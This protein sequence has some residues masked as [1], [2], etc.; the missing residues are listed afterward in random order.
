MEENKNLNQEQ[1]SGMDKERESA[2]EE[3]KR[4]KVLSPGRMVLQRF[5][6]NKLAII[7]LVILVIMFV[8]SFLGM[9]F[10]RYEVAQVFKGQRNIKKDYATAVY[11]QE[12]R[13]T[14]AEGEEFPTSARTQLMLAIHTPGDKTTFE[15]DGIGY[16][17]DKLGKDLYRIIEL[18]KK[19]SVAIKG[20]SDVVLVDQNFK[21]TDTAKAGF[22]AAKT[23]GQTKF[24]ADGK[25]YFIT[26]DAKSFY[27]C[28]ADGIALASKEICDFIDTSYTDLAK[29]YEFREVCDAAVIAESKSFQYDGKEYALDVKTKKD[30]SGNVLTR[31][32][33]I[34]LDGKDILSISRILISATA[35]DI[36]LSPVFKADA[37]TAI[38]SGDDSFN[39]KSVNE[40]GKKAEFFAETTNANIYIKTLKSSELILT[41]EAPSSKHLLGTDANGMDLLTR[42]MFGG[43]ISLAVG[44][45]V[46]G[47]ELIIGIIFGGISGYFGGW[48]DMVCMRFV[49]LFNSIPYWPMLVIAGAVM[50][51]M[52]L[53]SIIRIF[54]LMFILGFLSWP[55]IA[56]IVR[57]QI[58]T[59]REQEFM[60][61]CE[62]NGIRTSRRIFKHLVPNVM[63]ILIVQ[64]TMGLGGII[65]TEATLSFLGLG[66][67]YPMASWGSIIQG[68]TDMFVMTNY[69]WIWLPAGFCILITVLGFNFVGD[70]LRDA[71]DPKMKR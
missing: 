9:M 17:F 29:K 25:T 43:R 65:I 12:F 38:A 70:G 27:L 10:S 47:I 2:V 67:K 24:D 62:A 54:A 33:V 42:L 53:D 61:A 8:F 69:W 58:L 11:N 49:D 6:R 68:A 63:P 39:F 22:L 15:A 48:V 45:I 59:L 52:K 36:Q 5:L 71:F 28:E 4:V 18:E 66:I 56:R 57:G 30:S 23:A 37:R 40:K 3:S 21:L 20:T 44:F 14:V 1:N 51:S 64:A 60:V 41:Y 50:D 26:K 31:S 34:K 19:A 13:Y 55:G 46:I 35:T 32:G 16:Q 7:G